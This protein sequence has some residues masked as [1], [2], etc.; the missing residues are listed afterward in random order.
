M[1]WKFTDDYLAQYPALKQSILS[2]LDFSSHTLGGTAFTG[3]LDVASTGVALS[4][5]GAMLGLTQIAVSGTVTVSGDTLTVQFGST[6][7]VAFQQGAAASLPLIGSAITAAGMEV[8]TKVSTKDDPDV[9]PGTDAIDFKVTFAVAQATATIVAQVPMNGGVMSLTGTF[10][11]I[12]IQLSDLNFLFGKMGSV[13]Q[14]F[15][16]DKLTPYTSGSPSFGLIGMTLTGFITLTPKFTFS[17]SAVTVVV[18]IQ[19]LPLMDTKLYMDP[20]GVWITVTDPLGT[21]DVSW[22]LEGAIKLCNYANPGPGGLSKPDFI[23]DFSM[24]FPTATNKDFTVSGLFENPDSLTVGVMIQDLLGPGTDV[25]IGKTLTIDE[26]QFDATADVSSGKITDFSTSI[27]MSGGF[28]LLENF[29]L[30]EIAISIT[31]TGAAGKSGATLPEIK[32]Q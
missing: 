13:T 20:L 7:A 19:K 32:P 31:Y 29:D 10:E 22:G 26:F 8:L 3:V 4:T 27:A 16:G 24:G 5:L 14:W 17:L 1:G 30:E 6:D 11:G 25:G 15:P 9:G 28:G 18:G 12:G 21:P 2:H 23:F